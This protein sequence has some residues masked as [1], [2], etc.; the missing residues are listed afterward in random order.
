MMGIALVYQGKD[1]NSTNPA[2]LKAAADL[3]VAA[4]RTKNCMGFKPGVGGKNDVVAGTAVAAIVY[5]GDAIQSVTEEPDK[6]GFVIP[7]EGSEIWYDSMCI[8]GK[9]PNPDAAHKWINW[10][11]EPEVGAELSNY[12]QYA[13][14]NQAAEAFITPEDLKNP[15]IYP[16]PAI[17]KKLHFTKDLGK[18]NRI[19]DEAWTRAK[20]H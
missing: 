4:K 19:M 20:S 17:M 18:E 12:N 8:P 5:N 9:A 16:T 6:L 11:L 7:N 10:I 15:G 3:L 1:F 13:T 14:P 2:D